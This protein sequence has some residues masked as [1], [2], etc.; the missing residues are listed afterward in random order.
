MKKKKIAL[1]ALGLCSVL[2]IT[3]CDNT[4][5]SSTTSGSTPTQ[6]TGGS[7]SSGSSNYTLP[8]V[9][10][11]NP[12]TK[13]TELDVLINYISS[14]VGYGI[15]LQNNGGSY[16]NPIDGQTYTEGSILPTWKAFGDKLGMTMRDVADYT[17]TSDN[18]QYEKIYSSVA[19]QA[20]RFK[21]KVVSTGTGTGTTQTV[22]L[23]MNSASN[24]EKVAADGGLVNLLEYLDAMPN[25]KAWLGENLDTAKQLINDS[26][27]MYVAPYFDGKDT[28]ERMFLM[29]TEMVKKIL[30]SD[31]V[32]YNTD[33]TIT[34]EYTKFIATNYNNT[35]IPVVGMDKK[36]TEITVSYSANIIDTQNAL[37]TK[38]GQT[39]TTALKDYL[40][41]TYG[42]YVGSGKLYENLSD[43]FISE[44]ACYN[45]DE[46]IALMR[47]IKTNSTLITGDAN[48][49]VVT[50]SPRQAAANRAVNVL[51][52]AQIWGIQGLTSEKD[53]LYFDANGELQDAR[54]QEETYTVGLA[55]LQKL[56]KEGLILTNYAS[57]SST[58][59]AETY[60]PQSQLFMEYDYNATSAV[61][62]E[63]DAETG[64]G[65]VGS[66]SKG[67]KPVL[68]PVTT[69]ANDPSDYT[70]TRHSDDGRA[71][72]SGGWVI[73]KATDNLAGALAL[74]DYIFSQEGAN[75]QDFGPAN[76][77]DGTMTMPDGTVA[78]KIKTAVLKAISEDTKK[79]GWNNWY[80][81]YVGSTQG[82]GHVRSNALDYQVTHKVG[83]SG[84][85]NVNT[86]IAAGVYSIAVTSGANGFN[87]CVPT[88]W[89]LSSSDE[90]N[91]KNSASNTFFTNFWKTGD[92]DTDIHKYVYSDATTLSTYSLANIKAQF[93]QQQTDY[94]D[95]YRLYL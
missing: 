56:Y 34:T 61:Y 11:K 22:D 41:S 65:T 76:Y 63:Q 80:R 43:I 52:F 36:A 8:T 73:P 78:P 48:K 79:L 84:L 88:F 4:K 70:Y 57:S 85:D 13:G 40:K 7:G 9:E 2:A 44:N 87:K 12:G 28:I 27:E 91:L 90:E 75:L 66:K 68:A 26:N 81:R 45:P 55:N 94:L 67:F 23:W 89:N 51:Q 49:E 16:T 19:N 31:T 24:M 86:A 30:D 47:C 46:L 18:N 71:V 82:I 42:A 35:K 20:D 3:G 58:K 64:I 72:K 92:L 37:A 21:S 38:N 14:K 60:I 50:I 95:T 5:E 29:D 32:T 74:I 59:Y 15:S 54:L 33:R 83:Q 10:Q 39:L 17:A 62:N 77:V 1:V 25:F 6:T 53:F 93:A 69:W